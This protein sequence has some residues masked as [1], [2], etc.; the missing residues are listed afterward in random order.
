M[1]K[2]KFKLQPL[3]Q[4]REFKEQTLKTELGQ[5]NQ[6]LSA[7]L[8]KINDL[9][10]ALDQSY[11]SQNESA[12]RGLTGMQISFYP[13]YQDAVRADI[14]RQNNRLHALRLNYMNKLKELKQQRAQVKVLANLK[15]KNFVDFKK[16]VNKEIEAQSFE[17]YQLSSLANKEEGES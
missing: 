10:N 17:L 16:E 13:Q 6:L 4:L 5:I 12:K 8:D 14:Q 9:N 1:K 11:D 2:F 3:L 7:T 15:D